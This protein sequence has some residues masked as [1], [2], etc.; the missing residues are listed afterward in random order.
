MMDDGS[1][2]P[3]AAAKPLVAGR[4]ELLVQAGQGGMGVVYRARD[5]DS[6]ELVA[7]KLV[8]AR[9]ARLRA[10]FDLEASLLRDLSHP[11]IVR[12]VAHGGAADGSS[13]ST[14]A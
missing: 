3:H 10:R 13:L 14:R 9:N 8:T 7:L 6:G 12:Y 5:R 2:T 1:P 11:G 4:F